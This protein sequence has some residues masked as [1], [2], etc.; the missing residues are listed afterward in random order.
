VL[1]VDALTVGP[2]RVVFAPGAHSKLDPV[3]AISLVS[4]QPGKYSLT[5]DSKFIAKVKTLSLQELYF[6]VAAILKD[7]APRSA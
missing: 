1:G 5:P 4:G 2:E 7:L 3:R 6:T